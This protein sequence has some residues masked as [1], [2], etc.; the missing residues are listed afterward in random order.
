MLARNPQLMPILPIMPILKIEYQSLS[1][2]ILQLIG[3]LKIGCDYVSGFAM[4]RR[5][6]YGKMS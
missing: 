5:Q 1:V 2:Q 4:V 3:V 6:L